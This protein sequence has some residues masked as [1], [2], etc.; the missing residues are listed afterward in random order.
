MCCTVFAVVYTA[1]FAIFRRTH[2]H[3][4]VDGNFGLK[5]LGVK[6]EEQHLPVNYGTFPEKKMT[7]DVCKPNRWWMIDLNKLR[8]K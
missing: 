5:A 8:L 7:R 2:R 6:E 3:S 1:G 4:D